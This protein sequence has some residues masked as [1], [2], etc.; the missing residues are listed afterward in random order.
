MMV[1]LCH[2]KCHLA[3]DGWWKEV[4]TTDPIEAACAC[5]KCQRKHC[6][7]LLDLP[8]PKKVKA[9]WVVEP[10]EPHPWKHS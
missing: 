2:C 3:P 10:I 5:S 9:P 4:L 6:P 7:A 1:R 8:T